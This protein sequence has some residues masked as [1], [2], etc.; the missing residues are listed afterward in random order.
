MALAASAYFI[1]DFGLTAPLGAYGVVVALRRGVAKDEVWLFL[2]LLGVTCLGFMFFVSSPNVGSVVFRKAGLLFRLPLLAF[3]GVALLH[4]GWGKPNHKAFTWAI[5]VGIAL[6]LPTP[7]L[8]AARLAGVPIGQRSVFHVAPADARAYVWMREH[9]PL[10]AVVQ[11]LPSDLSSIPALAERR[12]AL[13]EW[14]NASNYQIGVPRVQE[15]QRAVFELF[16]SSDPEVALRICTELGIDH[17]YLGTAARKRLEP[18]A[19]AKFGR[20]PAFR[21][22]YEKDDVALYAIVP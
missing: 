16:R 1:I 21:I 10:E 11:E 2:A 22:L 18:V 13:G 9:L 15:R 8:D 17:L 4:A 3:A 12:T 19:S 5:L 6:A 20:S 7:L 14:I